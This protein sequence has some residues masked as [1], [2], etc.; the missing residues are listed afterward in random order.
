MSSV[1]VDEPRPL[2]KRTNPDWGSLLVILHKGSPVR[3]VTPGQSALRGW[4][5]P[6]IGTVEYVQINTSVV[7]ARQVIRDIV[8]ADPEEYAVEELVL[9][10]QVQ[11]DTSNKFSAFRA[12]VERYGKTFGEALLLEV[13]NG[14]DE[15]VRATFG[16]KTHRE[17]RSAS[18]P[19]VLGAGGYPR[20]FGSGVLMLT[21]VT[22]QGSP[23]WSEVYL[24]QT[25]VIQTTSVRIAEVDQNLAV[26]SAQYE[27]FKPLAAELGVPV[28][29][30]LD[31]ARRDVVE[32]RAHELLL[33]MMEPQNRGLLQRDPGV[34]RRLLAESGLSNSVASGRAMSAGQKNVDRAESVVPDQLGAGD[35]TADGSNDDAALDL[36]MD[37]RLGRVWTA[38]G[39][40]TASLAGLAGKGIGDTATVVVVGSNGT[41]LVDPRF[42]KAL[43]TF[44]RATS[45][46]VIALPRSSSV[47]LVAGW[48]AR[49]RPAD[50]DPSLGVR[51]EVTVQDQ[52]RVLVTGPAQLAR[53]LVSE[54]S[55]PH[56]TEIGALEN[57]LPYAGV[58]IELDDAAPQ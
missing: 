14:L 49:V 21:G 44:Y 40:R 16:R 39:G 6:V 34:L 38:N 53:R 47:E 50:A 54:L 12:H 58:T 42:V 10:I 52:L 48:F 32:G 1:F 17:L 41:P 3:V 15:H 11:I 56:R 29:F 51:A 45:V 43:S 30:L 35:D 33:R 7:T 26:T 20:H 46:V 18:I 36:T 19:Q 13:K 9:E 55:A 57:V 25:R 31:P 2:T 24:D 37:S 5:A 27:R 8:T 4:R 22:V 28:D 23:R